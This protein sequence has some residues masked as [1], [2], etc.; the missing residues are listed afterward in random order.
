MPKKNCAICPDTHR[1]L[2]CHVTLKAI[3][4]KLSSV[5]SMGSHGSQGDVLAPIIDPRVSSIDKMTY[6]GLHTGV[7][8]CLV[9]HLRFAKIQVIYL[10][11]YLYFS[12]N[13]NYSIFTVHFP[14]RMTVNYVL[15]KRRL[16]PKQ[17]T[18]RMFL[19]INN[20]HLPRAQVPRKF[21]NLLKPPTLLRRN[22]YT[23][24]RKIQA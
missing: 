21:Q 22:S 17:S 14:I 24:C 7:I 11:N 9:S 2:L 13:S 16:N 1:A 5:A 6:M 3:F 20:S 19:A 8:T 12:I 18:Q 15:P 23:A 4:R 10:Q